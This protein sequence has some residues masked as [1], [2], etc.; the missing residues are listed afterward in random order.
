MQRYVI[1]KFKARVSP[2]EVEAPQ[3]P[4][5]A[6]GVKKNILVRDQF[7][8]KYGR[9][10][11]MFI[12]EIDQELI[13]EDKKTSVAGK[14]ISKL[15]QENVG[16]ILTNITVWYHAITKQKITAADLTHWDAYTNHDSLLLVPKALQTKAGRIEHDLGLDLTNFKSISQ[17]TMMYGC[18][19]FET[20]QDCL[21]PLR[22][23]CLSL[24]R[25]I[26][27]VN[28]FKMLIVKKS[29]D[30]MQDKAPWSMCIDGHG[31][32]SE[33]LSDSSI[34]G[35]KSD[36]FK[37]LLD[38]INSHIAAKIVI[39]HSCSAGSKTN[40]I[41]L[42]HDNQSPS[43]YNFTLVCSSFSNGVATTSYD[44]ET[45][46]R[47]YYDMKRFLSIMHRTIIVPENAQ[48]I[49]AA[50]ALIINPDLE[51]FPHVRWAGDDH[52]Q[53]LALKDPDVS[54]ILHDNNSNPSQ[55]NYILNKAVINET[56]T[57]DN[58]ESFTFIESGKPE[59][60]H[61]YIKKIHLAKSKKVEDLFVHFLYMVSKSYRN[62]DAKTYLIDQVT[63]A[64]NK[65]ASNVIIHLRNA[66]GCAGDNQPYSMFFEQEGCCYVVHVENAESCLGEAKNNVYP[67]I[68][69]EKLSEVQAK[70]Y[71]QDYMQT[72]KKMLSNF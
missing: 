11:S 70:K 46:E 15:L 41:D 48:K 45:Y 3:L 31:R 17:P 22:E 10:I 2:F 50:I 8:N 61:H 58:K 56:L 18:P 26:H 4:D 19:D 9:H 16:L 27:V 34:S 1:N 64:N 54:Y 21:L 28:S 72:K 35:I 67:C 66:D 69:I 59:L 6:G 36:E 33:D 43:L 37:E 60:S 42:Y 32:S 25:T 68:K 44:R 53:L 5:M 71:R 52:F 65:T 62:K 29:Q 14:H 47:M 24:T 49:C 38:Y 51:N 40:L 7:L 39:Y 63:C 23:L 12:D 13:N 55:I 57:L 20:L 30:E